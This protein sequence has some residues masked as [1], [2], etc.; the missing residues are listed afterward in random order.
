MTTPLDTDISW[1]VTVLGQPGCLTIPLWIEHGLDCGP[2]GSSV[3][4]VQVGDRVS[5]VM[6]VHM[7][8]P[9]ASHCGSLREERSCSKRLFDGTANYSTHVWSTTRTTKR[10][11]SRIS[12]GLSPISSASDRLGSRAERSRATRKST[13]GMIKAGLT[14]TRLAQRSVPAVALPSLRQSKTAVW[15]CS[16]EAITPNSSIKLTRRRPGCKREWTTL[17]PTLGREASSAVL[18]LTSLVSGVMTESLP[19]STVP[20]RTA[21]LLALTVAVVRNRT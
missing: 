2:T 10:P 21:P 18:A 8:S 16:T 1:A 4:G 7:P 12:I 19:P 11:Q 13:L 17:A 9:L 3:A 5:V 20:Y 15:P 14:A 6:M